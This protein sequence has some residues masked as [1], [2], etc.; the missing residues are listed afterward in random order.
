MKNIKNIKYN[1]YYIIF[2]L[3]VLFL[4]VLNYNNL[5]NFF[6]IKEG[7]EGEERTSEV[8]N[9][10]IAEMK[11]NVFTDEEIGSTEEKTLKEF[12]SDPEMRG[13]IMS[14]YNS[15]LE[16]ST[17]QNHDNYSDFKEEMEKTKYTP[18]KFKQQILGGMPFVASV[19]LYLKVLKDNKVD[20]ISE[21]NSLGSMSKAQDTLDK[22]KMF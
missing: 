21:S 15:T 17:K 11:K 22:L 8:I 18:L 7:K 10:E 12:L 1:N 13:K 20:L 19:G 16:F 9:Q 3:I 6:K 5:T 14:L 2:G 4:V